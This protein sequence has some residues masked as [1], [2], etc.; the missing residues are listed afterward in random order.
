MYTFL[1]S[2]KKRK[3]INWKGK[4]DR[5]CREFLY[6]EHWIQNALLFRRAGNNG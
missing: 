5:D 6:L 4:G 2:K 3:K 1:L